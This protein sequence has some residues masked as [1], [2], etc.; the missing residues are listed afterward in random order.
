MMMMMMERTERVMVRSMCGVSRKNRVPTVE[1]NRR[2]DI[3][4]VTDVVRCGRLRWF[5]HVE[6]KMQM[7]G[8]LPVEI[9]K[10]QVREVGVGR[11]GMNV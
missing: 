4:A 3:E 10:L 9:L 5:G 7:T 2:L 11:R 8:Y 1:L 6:R